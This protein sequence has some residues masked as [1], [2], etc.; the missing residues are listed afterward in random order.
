ME[1]SKWNQ[2]DRQEQRRLETQAW[3]NLSNLYLSVERGTT[4]L[5]RHIANT[6]FMLARDA[7]PHNKSNNG[8]GFDPIEYWHKEFEL[9]PNW[10]EY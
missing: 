5:D 2:W 3:I 4:K 8:I 10:F 9:L 1:T 7:Y 6:L